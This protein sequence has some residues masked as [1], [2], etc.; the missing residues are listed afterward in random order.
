MEKTLAAVMLL[1][2]A[3]MLLRMAIGPRRRARLDAWWARTRAQGRS[4]WWR[5]RHWR[6]HRMDA[7]TQAEEAIRRAQQ[8]VRRDGNVYHPKNFKGP[9]KPH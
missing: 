6:S 9:R 7:A 1:L 2:C 8:S 4:L 3:G 5:A